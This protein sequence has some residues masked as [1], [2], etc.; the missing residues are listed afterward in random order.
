MPDAQG[1]DGKTA[2]SSPRLDVT[3][4][5]LMFPFAQVAGAGAVCQR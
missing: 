4:L 2:A 3:L 5:N 1:R